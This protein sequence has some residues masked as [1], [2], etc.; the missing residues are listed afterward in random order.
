MGFLAVSAEHRR[1]GVAV[2][3]VGEVERTA[4]GMGFSSLEF[5]FISP[6]HWLL[7]FYAK[8]GYGLTGAVDHPAEQGWLRPEWRG[9]VAFPHMAKA[10]SATT[11][12]LAI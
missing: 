11:R 8:L 2:A 1:Q 5:S 9:K 12:P 6:Q 10:L 4:A 7:G 3:L